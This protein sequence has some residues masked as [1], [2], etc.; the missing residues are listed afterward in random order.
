MKGDAEM[1][2]MI[3]DYWPIIVP[4][5]IAT[6]DVGLGLLPT[7]YVR[8]AGVLISFGKAVHKKY[9]ERSAR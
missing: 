6:A 8:Y 4:V 1:I 7:K 9:K 3:T 2:E 5:L